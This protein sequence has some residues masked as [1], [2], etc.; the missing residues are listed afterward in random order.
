MNCFSMDTPS[1]FFFFI[2]GPE[3]FKKLKI[4]ELTD[5]CQECVLLLLFVVVV[6]VQNWFF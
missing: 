6:L 2:S 3:I 5:V 1:L 4:N